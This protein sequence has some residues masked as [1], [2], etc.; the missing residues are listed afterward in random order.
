MINEQLWIALLLNGP[1]AFA[2]WRRTGFPAL[3]PSTNYDS[4]VQTTPRRFEYPI[5]ELE[6]NAANA[7]AAV[8]ALGPGGNSWLN[9]VWWDKP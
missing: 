2:N 3:K 6:Q 5:Y 8:T 7:A 4:S 9:R 1:E